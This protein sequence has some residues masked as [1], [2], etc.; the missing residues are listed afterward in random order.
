MY[1]A[2]SSILSTMRRKNKNQEEDERLTLTFAENKGSVSGEP[3]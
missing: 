3:H 1:K 2:L